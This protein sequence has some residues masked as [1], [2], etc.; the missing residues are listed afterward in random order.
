MPSK[1]CVAC[2]EPSPGL[3]GDRRVPYPAFKQC[4][5]D[6]RHT[7]CGQGTG[8]AGVVQRCQHTHCTVTMHDTMLPLQLPDLKAASCAHPVHAAPGLQHTSGTCTRQV[9]TA[10]KSS[11]VTGCPC[12][13]SVALLVMSSVLDCWGTGA[14][15]VRQLCGV[16]R[17]V[18]LCAPAPNLGWAHPTL[19]IASAL[20]ENLWALPM[21]HSDMSL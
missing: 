4:G 1:C 17:L 7:Q 11:S 3:L 2:R 21:Y 19:H 12:Q 6:P 15:R 16:C 13:A 9:A 8:L 18:R 14:I 10:A 5:S 20:L